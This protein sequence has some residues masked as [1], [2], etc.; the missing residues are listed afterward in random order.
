MSEFRGFSDREIRN[1]QQQEGVRGVAPLTKADLSRKRP[2]PQIMTRNKMKTDCDS[3]ADLPTAAY[4]AEQ[5]QPSQLDQTGPN[6]TK[7][8]HQE[9]RKDQTN[10]DGRPSGVD[11]TT[12][13]ATRESSANSEEPNLPHLHT[14]TQYVYH[15]TH[16]QYSEKRATKSLL[17][18]KFALRSCDS[19]VHPDRLISVQMCC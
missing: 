17:F 12:N 14:D 11:T 7:T 1:L 3:S 5:P 19:T 10:Q 2:P 4:F 16:S 9:P 8:D 15:Y 13:A 18:F 6:D